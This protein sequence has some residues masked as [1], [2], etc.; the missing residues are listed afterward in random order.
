MKLLSPKQ[1][2]NLSPTAKYARPTLA[3]YSTRPAYVC[4][5]TL[6]SSPIYD[7]PP[8]CNDPPYFTLTTA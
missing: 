6:W 2:R 8:L 4:M 5:F 3:V 7:H 1:L